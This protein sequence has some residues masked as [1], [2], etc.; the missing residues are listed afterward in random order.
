MFKYF[1]YIFI[2]LII[3]FIVGFCVWALIKKKNGICPFCVIKQYMLKSKLTIKVPEN[4]FYDGG[5]AQTPPMGWSSWNTFR[6]NIDEKLILETADALVKTGLADAGYKYVNLDDCWHSSMRDENGRLQGDLVRFSSG[7]DW[8]ADKIRSKGLKIGL[9]SSNGDYTCEDLPASSGNEKTDAETFARWGVEYFK[10]DFCHNIKIPS[11]APLVEAI[12]LKQGDRI[13]T[14]SADKAK[15]EGMAKINKDKKLKTGKYLSFLGHGKGKAVFEVDCESD[16]DCDFTLCIKK[17]GRFEKYLVVQVNDK[18]YEMFIPYTKSWSTAGRYQTRIQVKKGKNIVKT[19][20]PVCTRADSSYIQ[21]KRM[22][23]ALKNAAGDKKITYSICEWGRNKPEKWAWN[24][25]NLWRIS[26]DIIPSWRWINV[27]YNMNIRLAEYA[28]PGHWNDPDMLEVG[29]GK[30]TYEENKTHFSLW[31]MMAAPL[32]LGNDI[33]KLPDEKRTLDIISNKDM[34]AINQD[35]AG[36]QCV[37][38][39]RTFTYDFLM[40]KLAD[41]SVAICIYNKRK[42]PK[43]IRISKD[44]FPA[45]MPEN[46]R[47]IKEIWTKTD[48][49]DGDIFAL[50]G[51]DCAV[52]IVK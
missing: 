44:I 6:N 7:I 36:M 51:H 27:L 50:K 17:S 40:K 42:S 16:G 52:F 38:Y 30:L 43:K 33:R 34:I 21:Y 8:L 12:E 46:S 32:I 3:V 23:D 4:E 41:G 26:P 48:V 2:I 24:A 13:N 31:C 45:E 5:D 47:K 19:F 11:V 22:G 25:G 49:S 35:N 15:L 14:Y 9:Y 29:N 18:F 39:K 10:Y 20:N 1:I 37:R 28:G